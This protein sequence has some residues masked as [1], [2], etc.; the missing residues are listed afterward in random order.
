MISSSLRRRTYERARKSQEPP[1]EQESDISWL[2][3]DETWSKGVA[4]AIR[5][6]RLIYILSRVVAWRFDWESVAW[7]VKRKSAL[8]PIAGIALML[9]LTVLQAGHALRVFEGAYDEIP[10]RVEQSISGHGAAATYVPLLLAAVIFLVC[11]CAFVEAVAA[12]SGRLSRDTARVAIGY[13]L[14]LNL[15]AFAIWFATRRLP[16]REALACEIVC[17]GLTLVGSARGWYTYIDTG[18]RPFARA[19][20]TALGLLGV[21]LVF[22]LAGYAAA[23]ATK[24]IVPF[25]T[26]LNFYAYRC[27]E[28]RG[29][30]MG[31]TGYV[32]N[33]SFST[34]AM[35]LPTARASYVSPQWPEKEEP[36]KLPPTDMTYVEVL[37]LGSEPITD[38]KLLF[39]EPGKSLLIGFSFKSTENICKAWLADSGKNQA[40]ARVRIELYAT[41]FTYPPGDEEETDITGGDLREQGRKNSK[42]GELPLQYMNFNDMCGASQPR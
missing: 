39:L 37:P 35:R 25:K 13:I 7:E 10:S 28:A 15:L 3:P 2:S 26:T 20:L 14:T 16:E 24:S 42:L 38:V 32:Y 34:F 1:S 6:G 18:R 33:P 21:P 40:L 41:K 27:G 36:S 19:V 5:I 12:T 31:C 22:G 8:G 9:A 23:S 4:V 11:V 29:A 30:G 17:W